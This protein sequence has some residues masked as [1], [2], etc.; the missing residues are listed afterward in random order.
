MRFPKNESKIEELEPKV[1]KIE[2]K[3][4]L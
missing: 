4:E 3:D 1:G 2:Y